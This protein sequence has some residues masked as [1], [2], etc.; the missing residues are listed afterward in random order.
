MKIALSKTGGFT[1]IELMIV[2]A[3]IGILAAIAIPNYLGMQEKAK[4]RA[5]EEGCASA[6]AEI[7]HWMDT[8][9]RGEHGLIDMDGD[10]DIDNNDDTLVDSATLDTDSNTGVISLWAAAMK[11]KAGGT[12][13]GPWGASDLYKIID[14]TG[15]ANCTSQTDNGKINLCLTNA[16]TVRVIGTDENGNILF[17]DSV[18]I[19]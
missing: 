12:L 8:V 10:G 18:S 19:E 1:L 5:I 16:R 17:N 3:L 4:R 6:K 7:A 13:K 14:G 2:V 15:G 9:A 11:V